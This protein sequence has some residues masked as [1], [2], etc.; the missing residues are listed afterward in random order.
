M[1]LILFIVHQNK[2]HIKFIELYEINQNEILM[3]VELHLNINAEN[4]TAL[5]V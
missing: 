4:V 3:K 5:N 1:Y 2:F